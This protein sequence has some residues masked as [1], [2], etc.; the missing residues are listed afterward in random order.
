MYLSISISHCMS[1]IVPC[2]HRENYLLHQYC[3]LFCSQ[4]IIYPSSL[5]LMKTEFT[6]N[7]SLLQKKKND[8]QLGLMSFHLQMN[9]IPTV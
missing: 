1:E 4:A 2:L 6:S 3:V 5:L 7:P 9:N 8:E